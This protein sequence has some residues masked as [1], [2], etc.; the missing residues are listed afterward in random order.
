[1]QDGNLDFAL[2]QAQTAVEQAPQDPHFADTLGWILY[3]K[4]AYLRAQTYL[5][6]AASKLPSSPTVL[7]HYGMAQYKSGDRTGAQ[8]TLE[9]SLKL[10]QTFIGAEEAKR[11]LTELSKQTSKTG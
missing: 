2:S 4:N 11:T 7:F 5:K 6:D 3:K 1:M 8:R 9:A 10:N